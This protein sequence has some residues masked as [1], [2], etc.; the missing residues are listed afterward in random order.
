MNLPGRRS[1]SVSAYSSGHSLA[2]PPALVQALSAVSGGPDLYKELL[3]RFW[4]RGLLCYG[5]DLPC[6]MCSVG[7]G[8][9]YLCSGWLLAGFFPSSAGGGFWTSL[10]LLITCHI[11]NVIKEQP[12]SWDRRGQEASTVSDLLKLTS[13]L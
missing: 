11:G 10:L 7:A 5:T 3:L 13:H 4:T 9:L 12:V 1:T 6:C 8:V 2:F